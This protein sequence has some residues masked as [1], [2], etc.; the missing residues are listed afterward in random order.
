MP[1]KKKEAISVY[2]IDLKGIVGENIQ[3]AST[4]GKVQDTQCED[5]GYTP[6]EQ[7]Q[8][9]MGVIRNYAERIIDEKLVQDKTESTMKKII[10]EE[11]TKRAVTLHQEQGTKQEIKKLRQSV[12]T[13]ESVIMQMKRK[14]ERLELSN[15]QKD[16]KIKDLKLKLDNFEQQGFDHSLQIVG[17]PEG[18]DED[19]DMKQ[20]IKMSKTLGIKVKT[21]DIENMTRLGKKKEHKTRNI[22]VKLR[23]KSTRD[24]MFEQRKRLL[25]DPNPSK[26]C[27]LMTG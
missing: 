27:T 22:I 3:E 17:M 13:L 19:D 5:S 15:V 26:M 18:R 6:S 12:E 14:V 10:S 2:N 23:D 1:R 8:W 16:N 20:V 24:R 21:S 11:I 9:I 4:S 25:K 7:T